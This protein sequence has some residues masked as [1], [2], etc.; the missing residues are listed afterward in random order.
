MAA[1]AAAAKIK[2]FQRKKLHQQFQETSG[3]HLRLT[4]LIP[5]HSL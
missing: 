1:P 5:K 4:F 2:N 3:H